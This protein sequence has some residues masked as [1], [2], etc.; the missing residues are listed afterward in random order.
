MQP[1]IK[2][3]VISNVKNSAPEEGKGIRLAIYQGEGPVGT[4]EAVQ[5]NLSVLE[6][7]VP[8]A[9]WRGA[10]LVVFP[11]KY[12]TG[13][14]ITVKQLKDEGMAEELN[15]PEI[16][17][18][19]KVAEKNNVAIIL[20]YPEVDHSEGSPKYY[21]SIAFIGPNGK[22]LSNYRK[23]HLYGAAERRN[24]SFGN[25]LPP[26]NMV[27]GFPVG[28]LNCYECEFP[29]LY[30][31][32]ATQGAKLIV[33][34]TAADY[35][36]PLADGSPTQVPYQDATEHIIP[37]LSSIYKVFVAYAN[38]R[39]WEQVPAGFWQYRGNS[40]VWAPN[41]KTVISCG[42]EEQTNDTLL[43][44]DCTPEDHLPFSPEGNHLLDSRLELIEKLTPGK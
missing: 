3:R 16:K 26:V 29:E 2:L 8:L 11:E 28:I 22:V 14:A 13:Y 23:T 7:V 17:F 18:V 35:H 34:P 38:R 32:L 24:Y 10:H 27:N 6:K 9:K 41:G 40:G 4:K 5:H 30:K 1:D 25:E 20:P 37:A 12:T 44:A 42:L 43:I 15:G 19:R 21:D 31:Y 36:F 33:G 39:G